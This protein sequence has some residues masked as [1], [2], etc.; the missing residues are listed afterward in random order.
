MLNSYGDRYYTASGSKVYEAN[1]FRFL[2]AHDANY[3]FFNNQIYFIKQS[4]ATFLCLL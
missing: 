3:E 4:N 1:T 2:R